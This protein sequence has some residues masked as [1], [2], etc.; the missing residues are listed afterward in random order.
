MLE[1]IFAKESFQIR[2]RAWAPKQ[3]HDRPAAPHHAKTSVRE[4]AGPK[5]RGARG[6]SPRRSFLRLS[7][8]KA[9]LPPGV[10]RETHVAGPTLRRSKP[11]PPADTAA[12]HPTGIGKE[13][14][15]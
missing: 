12:P 14:P 15:P 11:K 4:R 9:G 5:S 1:S 7:P 3:P 13:N 8:E 2:V 10:G 6:R